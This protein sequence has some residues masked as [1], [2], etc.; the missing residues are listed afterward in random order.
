[1]I[2]RRARRRPAPERAATA[3]KFA[4]EAAALAVIGLLALLAA[5]LMF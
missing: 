2:R 1:M 3:A 5:A 4:T